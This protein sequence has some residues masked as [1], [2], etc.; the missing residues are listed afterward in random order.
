MHRQ[1]SV[2]TPV[3]CQLAQALLS[4]LGLPGWLLTNYYYM[5]ILRLFS[6]Q[7]ECTLHSEHESN[8]IFVQVQSCDPVHLRSFLCFKGI[9][10]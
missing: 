4:K 2:T 9:K 5:L 6:M 7:F 8:A 1:M 3:E 10:F